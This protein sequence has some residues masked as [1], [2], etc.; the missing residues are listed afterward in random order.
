M[1]KKRGHFLVFFVCVRLRINL[2][3]V[4][5]C[6]RLLLSKTKKEKW[7]TVK[8]NILSSTSKKKCFVLSSFDHEIF[9]GSWIPFTFLSNEQ[10]TDK[11]IGRSF[12]LRLTKTMFLSCFCYKVFDPDLLFNSWRSHIKRL[13]LWC[14]CSKIVFST[15]GLPLERNIG[16]WH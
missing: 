11:Y 5:G 1:F 8:K 3:L 13:S 12:F 10:I 14:Y 15:R 6:S 7:W 2:I 9:I 16:L 4:Y